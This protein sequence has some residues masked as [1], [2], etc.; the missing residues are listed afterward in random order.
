M[1]ISSDRPD[2]WYSISWDAFGIWPIPTAG[3]GVLRIDYLAWPETL[4]S[5]T[6]SPM[7]RET[8]QDLIVQYGFYDGLARQW[9][10]E[11]AMDIFLQF[12]GAFKDQEFK[13]KT[14]RFHYQMFNRSSEG[15][16]FPRL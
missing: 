6:D 4:L 15:I 14:R 5:D 8:E 11:R 9:E 12:V 7:L 16:D 2:W 13:N 3:G 10:P 1:E